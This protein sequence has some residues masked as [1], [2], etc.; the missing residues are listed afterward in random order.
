MGSEL[1]DYI[2]LYS[3]LMMSVS[4]FNRAQLDISAGGS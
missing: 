2:Y 4:C 3:L 1:F